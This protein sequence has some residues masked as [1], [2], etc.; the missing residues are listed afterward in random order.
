ML[1]QV[2]QLSLLH[3]FPI[4]KASKKFPL[5]SESTPYSLSNISSEPWAKSY[6]SIDLTGNAIRS[7]HKSRFT[8]RNF[9]ES[10]PI[11]RP[12]LTECT[13]FAFVLFNDSD[14]IADLEILGWV[15]R[16]S[17]ETLEISVLWRKWYPTSPSSVLSPL[18][19]RN[20]V[21]HHPLWCVVFANSQTCAVEL[22]VLTNNFLTLTF[23]SLFTLNSQ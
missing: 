22:P 16:R 10:A 7:W 15:S 11:N 3:D 9:E 20:A 21:N 18:R 2:S 23:I 13:S 4:I 19:L 12:H 14:C 5:Y 8:L 17:S 1:F 6:I